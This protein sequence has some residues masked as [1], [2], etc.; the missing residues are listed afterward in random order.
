MVPEFTFTSEEPL[1]ITTAIDENRDSG[2]RIIMVIVTVAA[3]G[4]HNVD[5]GRSDGGAGGA[6]GVA[7]LGGGGGA[8]AAGGEAGSAGSGGGE[9][10]SA[11][12]GAG[13]TEAGPSADLQC[14]TTGQRRNA[15][16]AESAQ[17][18]VCEVVSPADDSLIWRCYGPAPGSPTPSPKCTYEDANQGTGTG[19][20]WVNWAS[21]SDGQNYSLSCADQSCSCLID[22]RRT[23]IQV[24]P[25]DSCPMDLNGINA[26][27]GWNLGS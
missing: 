27:C 16:P 17:Y 2:I 25:R 5:A 13:S 15:T 1:P 14:E 11:G 9:S 3:C 10:S 4:G 26:V 18:C 8:G 20:C 22:G 23:T 19:S 7:G 12:S 21:C 24:E 6:G